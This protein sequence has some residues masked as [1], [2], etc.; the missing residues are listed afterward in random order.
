MLLNRRA[1]AKNKLEQLRNGQTAYAETF[2]VSDYLEKQIA[3][4][5]MN[6]VI[7]RTDRGNWFYPAQN[8][9]EEIL[10]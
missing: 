4:L 1:L 8:D 3:D 7:D 2:E 10:D 9:Q 6:V 5:E